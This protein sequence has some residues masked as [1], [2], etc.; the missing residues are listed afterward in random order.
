MKDNKRKYRDLEENK[1]TES[2]INKF[3][4]W[5]K[6]KKGPQYRININGV[7]ESNGMSQRRDNGDTK[8]TLLA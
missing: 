6:R 2:E 3:K 5:K 1:K 7:V 8:N 4:K